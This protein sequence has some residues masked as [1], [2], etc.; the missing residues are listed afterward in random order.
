MNFL[1]FFWLLLIL[2]LF[3]FYL[4]VVFNLLR[5]ELSL[6][7]FDTLS[8]TYYLSLSCYFY[9]S[10][11]LVLF[12]YVSVLPWIYFNKFYNLD[13]YLWLF[14]SCSSFKEAIFSTSYSVSD[15]SL[16]RLYLHFLIVELYRGVRKL[17]RPVIKEEWRFGDVM[18]F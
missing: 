2:D 12:W 13:W 1:F 17:V 16:K 10:I 4:R 14:F 8:D 7:T 6:D 5:F 15:L 9:S 11:L 18:L 3:S